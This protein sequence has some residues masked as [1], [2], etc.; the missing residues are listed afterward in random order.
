MNILILIS[1]LSFGGAEKQAVIDANLLSQY[2]KVFLGTF[3]D[4][5]LEKN[6]SNKVTHIL[7]KK[8]NYVFTAFRIIRFIRKNNIN[9]VHSLLFASMVISALSSILVKIPVIW[10]FHSHEFDS[11]LKSQIAFKYLARLKGVKRILFVNNELKDF[12]IKR[13]NL[14]VQKLGILYNSSTINNKNIFAKNNSDLVNIGFIG[15]LKDFKRVNYLLDL[16]SYLVKR[17]VSNFL[18]HIVGDGDRKK[19]LEKYALEFNV[20][21]F[22]KF[23]GYQLNTE[24]LYEKFDIFVNPSSEECLSLALI[25][26]GMKGIPAIAFNVGGNSEIIQ[27]NITGYIVR[28]KEELFKKALLLYKKNDLRKKLGENAIKICKEK[29]SEETHLKRLLCEYN[30]CITGK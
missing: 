19:R 20:Q 27:N 24:K 2:H 23:W 25:D 11:P 10:H 9:I 6:I 3:K 5:P 21:D 22:V 18:I 28:T 16:A 14:P 1:S 8:D 17:N 30:K 29:F 7:F 13:F 12:F 4:G 15:R 26:A